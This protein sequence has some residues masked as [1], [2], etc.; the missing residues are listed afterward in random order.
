MG[1][2]QQIKWWNA[3]FVAIGKRR[4]KG[5]GKVIKLKTFGVCRQ[6]EE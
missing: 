1:R 6:L 5:G 3:V 2:K 4:N